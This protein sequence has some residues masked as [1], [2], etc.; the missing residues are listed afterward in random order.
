MYTALL[1]LTL[2]GH[3]KFLRCITGSLLS[4]LL[5]YN[6]YNVLFML[7]KFFLRYMFAAY[8]YY[9]IINSYRITESIIPS[10]ASFH[11]ELLNAF[12]P[13]IG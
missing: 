12:S 10:S 11:L 7:H 4:L 3:L 1:T 2:Q 5:F 8:P 9:R 13:I 6:S